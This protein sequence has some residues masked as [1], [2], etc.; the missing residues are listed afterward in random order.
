MTSSPK[1]GAKEKEGK[2]KKGFA[3]DGVWDLS[4]IMGAPEGLQRSIQGG[5]SAGSTLSRAAERG[6]AQARRA[7]WTSVATSSSCRCAAHSLLIRYCLH[8]AIGRGE[9]VAAPDVFESA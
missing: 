1:A 6:G 3:D 7:R 4:M 5:P 8:G 9:T 2:K